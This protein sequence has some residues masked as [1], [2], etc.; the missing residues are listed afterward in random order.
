VEF[1]AGWLLA[2]ILILQQTSLGPRQQSVSDGKNGR[3]SGR[4]SRPSTPPALPV[5]HDENGLSVIKPA[6]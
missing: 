3:Q 1:L 6:L 4:N 2:A 5:N